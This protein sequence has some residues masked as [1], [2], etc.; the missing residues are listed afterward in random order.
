MQP[1]SYCYFARLTVNLFKCFHHHL[2]CLE[3]VLGTRE[4]CSSGP[5]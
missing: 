3:V 4:D 2:D 5:L 1:L